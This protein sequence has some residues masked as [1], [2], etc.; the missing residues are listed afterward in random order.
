LK[1]PG[2][3]DRGSFGGVLEPSLGGG[4]EG[5]ESQVRLG[6]PADCGAQGKETRKLGKG[7]KFSFCG[8]RASKKGCSLWGEGLATAK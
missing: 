5:G 8:E 6:R 2:K 1:E 4:G 7:E 3:E